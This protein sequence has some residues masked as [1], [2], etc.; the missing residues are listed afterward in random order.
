[1]NSNR[2]HFLCLLGASTG[3]LLLNG[4]TSSENQPA[5]RNTLTVAASPEGSP[6]ANPTENNAEIKGTIQ[7]P[8][9][10]YPY[11]LMPKQCS[12]TMTSTTQLM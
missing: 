3:A 4:C 9:L 5:V 6:T 1:M 12:F 2:R 7:L 10:P 8:P 11:I